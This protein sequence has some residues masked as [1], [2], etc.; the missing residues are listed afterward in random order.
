MLRTLAQTVLVR[1]LLMSSR[2]VGDDTIVTAFLGAWPQIPRTHVR[3][4]HGQGTNHPLPLQFWAA[5][6]WVDDLNGIPRLF[7]QP[8]GRNGVPLGAAQSWPLNE[9]TLP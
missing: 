9:E 3:V 4:L 8:L 7:R 5:C 6:L 1:N 2:P